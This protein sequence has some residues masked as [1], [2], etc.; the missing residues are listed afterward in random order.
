MVPGPANTANASPIC[1]GCKESPW[2]DG[3]GNQE[4]FKVAA[5]DWNEYHD[6]LPEP[7]TNK[8]LFCTPTTVRYTNNSA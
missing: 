1:L 6:S 3:K 5:E 2:T 4:R 7:N 8:I